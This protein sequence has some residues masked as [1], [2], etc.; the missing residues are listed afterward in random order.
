M[1]KL[2]LITENFPYGTTGE[3]TF[4]LSELPELVKYY[5]VTVISHASEAVV[6]DHANIAALPSEVKVVNL[7]IKLTWSKKFIYLIRYLFDGDGIKEIEEILKSKENFWQRLRYSISFYALAMEDFRLIRKEKLFTRDEEAIYYTYWY[8]YY[9]YSISKNRKYFPNMKVV[10]RAHGFD[11]YDEQCIGGR[12]SFQNIMDKNVDRI[13]FISEQGKKYYL[14]KYHFDNSDKYVVSRLGTIG[15]RHLP[16]VMSRGNGKFRLVSCSSAIPLKR[17]HLIVEALSGIT[18]DIEWIHF[19]DGLEFDNL[20]KLASRLLKNKS[21]IEYQLKGWISNQ[22]IVQ[23]Y[24]DNYVNC[25]ITTSST[26]GIPVSVQE[27]ISF[28]I[29]II[30]TAVG[31]MPE[32]FE[33]NGVLLK[34]D[35]SKKEIQNAIRKMIHMDGQAYEELR[36]NS[37]KVWCERYDAEVNRVRFVKMLEKL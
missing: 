30:A 8:Y 7:Q 24:R 10:T 34:M 32:L 27:A 36:K 37:Y 33:D 16:A 3:N 2:F 26:E 1:K 17:V 29:P 4:I 31:G 23:Y 20:E 11:L 22:E 5:D 18:E 19:G 13:F 14:N 15:T 21:N 25:F 12:Q 6:N 35:P 9:T 28:G